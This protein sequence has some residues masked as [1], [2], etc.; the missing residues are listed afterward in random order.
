M[1]M[2]S[3]VELAKTTSGLGSI[4]P[5]MLAATVKPAKDATRAAGPK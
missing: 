3:G 2:V 4:R 1:P 5:A